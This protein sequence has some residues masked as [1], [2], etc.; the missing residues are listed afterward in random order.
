MHARASALFAILAPLALVTAQ[1]DGDDEVDGGERVRP[2]AHAIE[3]EDVADHIAE[4]ER[5]RARVGL[6]LDGRRYPLEL[7]GLD[8]ESG[9]VV[10]KWDG[11]V[12]LVRV[13]P[14]SERPFPELT[15]H[16]AGDVSSEEAT[17]ASRTRTLLG[18]DVSVAE[19]DDGDAV[20]RARAVD[21]DSG[22]NVFDVTLVANESVV[23]DGLSTLSYD[24]DSAR[25][26]GLLTRATYV[27]LRDMIATR[28]E[29]ERIVFG[30]VQGS[31]EDDI[32]F[33]TGRMI[34]EAGLD[35]HVPADGSTVSGGVDLFIAGVR[36]TVE[37][38]GVLGIHSWCC[39]ENGVPG[40]RLPL[41]HEMHDVQ[42]TYARDVLGERGEAFYFH[43]LQAA[44]FDG[45]HRMS[46]E[47]MERFGVVT[48]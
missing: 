31:L 47:E 30:D 24:G 32:N 33:H 29:I 23:R 43:Q 36:R 13:D 9:R 10:L 39:D 41:D 37:P 5:R 14:E 34:R 2:E 38:G 42:V 48:D 25:L 7:A 1:A 22:E 8:T 27:K 16:E 15:L 17:L 11:G 18:E 35:T 28:P 46:R 21:A 44:P 3:P 20:W 26:D 19:N 12:V 6:E 40:N 45:M 4:F